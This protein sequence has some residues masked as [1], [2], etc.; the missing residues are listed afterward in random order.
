MMVQKLTWTWVTMNVL[1]ML[2]C[3]KLLAAPLAKSMLLFNKDRRGEYGGGTVQVI[4]HVT[5]EI[6]ERV[7]RAGR[8]DNADFVI[9][10]I[11]GT[12]GDI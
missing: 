7:F 3:P 9:T 5:N 2:T 6:K 10:E 8:E 11:G 4:P 12:V 1:L